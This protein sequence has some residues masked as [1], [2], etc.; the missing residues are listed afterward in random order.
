MNHAFREK[1]YNSHVH[2][3]IYPRYEVDPELDGITLNVPLFGEFYDNNARKLVNSD[4]VDH[5]ASKLR[6]NI[7]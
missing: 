5:I 2:W 4:V 6:Q 1:P 3:H 7:N